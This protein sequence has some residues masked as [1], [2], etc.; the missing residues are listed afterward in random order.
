MTNRD[1]APKTAIF[2]PEGAFGPTN[3]CIGIADV[4]RRRGHRVVFVVE[5]SFAGTLAARGFEERL[6]RLQ[7]PPEVPDF[8]RDTA[9]HFREP[10]REQLA[11]L[12]LPIWEQ[13]VAGAMYVE[14]RLGEIFAEVR[15]DVIVEDNVVG[16]PAVLTAGAPWVR[17]ISCN[18]LEIDDPGLPPAFSGLPV[19]DG[20]DW[21]AFRAAYAQLHSELHRRF[22]DFVMS[23]GC[24]SLPGAAFMFESPYLNLYVYPE[25]ADYTRTRPL[26]PT[27]HRLDSSAPSRHFRCRINCGAMAS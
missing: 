6:M 27:F 8:I 25:E 5:E 12:I 3:N 11:T 18:P 2:F 17:I 22:D 21:P 19:A 7:A 26:P 15:P 10:T 20:R 16:F 4:L 9:P 1:T 13:L 24:P 23:R 14:E